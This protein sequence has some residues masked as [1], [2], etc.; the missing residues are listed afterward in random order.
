[1]LACELTNSFILVIVVIL[2]NVGLTSHNIST[3]Y[4]IAG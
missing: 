1:M 4:N 2:S 3:V